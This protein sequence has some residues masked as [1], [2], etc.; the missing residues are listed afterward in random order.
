MR[1]P[2]SQVS[3]LIIFIIPYPQATLTITCFLKLS[4]LLIYTP[5]YLTYSFISTTC[6]L[7]TT[8]PVNI[9]LPLFINII[10]SILEGLISKLRSLSSL[11]SQ[12]TSLPAFSRASSTNNPLAITN[13]SSAYAYLFFL[14]LT[15]R[16][17]SRLK[18]T[19][20]IGD[21]YSSPSS[22]LK[23]FP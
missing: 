23:G 22:I 20:N 15:T 21:P 9:F 1:S 19:G 8:Y 17:S 3:F 6:P 4:L 18:I 2:I 11:A 14:S 12:F 7:I 16:L 10:A 5:K 13:T